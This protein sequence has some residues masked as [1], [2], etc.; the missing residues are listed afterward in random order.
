MCL[1]P[2]LIFPQNTVIP[3]H[4]HF[5]GLTKGHL[6]CCFLPRVIKNKKTPLPFFHL[7][8]KAPTHAAFHNSIHPTLQ[9]TPLDSAAVRSLSY[10]S[11]HK[12]Q[13]YSEL[14]CK[15]AVLLNLPADGDLRGLLER[16]GC[17]TRQGAQQ[18]APLSTA[19]S[20]RHSN[21]SWKCFTHKAGLRVNRCRFIMSYN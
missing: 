16:R 19:S 7:A 8:P 4:P 14:K 10:N 21:G 9:Q 13:C 20:H 5:L 1:L 11:S 3:L 15:S 12:F 6:R 18:S 17:A 2:H